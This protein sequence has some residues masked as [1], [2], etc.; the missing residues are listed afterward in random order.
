MQDLGSVQHLYFLV[1]GFPIGL[2]PKPCK[3]LVLSS[4]YRNSVNQAIGLAR[5]SPLAN[6]WGI[7]LILEAPSTAHTTGT[8]KCSPEWELS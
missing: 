6:V 8:S 7:D 4:T 5:I 1:T 2:S 3:T